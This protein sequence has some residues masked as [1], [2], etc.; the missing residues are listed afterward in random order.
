LRYFGL[1]ALDICEMVTSR[2]SG[3]RVTSG[4]N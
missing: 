3:M 1:V 4:D 2:L